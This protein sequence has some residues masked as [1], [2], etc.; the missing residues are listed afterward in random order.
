MDGLKLIP[1]NPC[2]F[3]SIY[4]RA[5]ARTLQGGGEGGVAGEVAE[6]PENVGGL[7]A[8]VDGRD[9]WARGWPGL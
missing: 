8:V 9:G 6:H 5:Q 3:L 7:G 4:V 1:T 2:C